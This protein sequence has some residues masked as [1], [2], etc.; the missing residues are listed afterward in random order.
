MNSCRMV[1]DQIS[2]HSFYKITMKYFLSHKQFSIY[3]KNCKLAKIFC[4][5]NVNPKF[6]KAHLSWKRWERKIFILFIHRLKKRSK[7]SNVKNKQ[8]LRTNKTTNWKKKCN[9]YYKKWWRFYKKIFAITAI[10]IYIVVSN[11]KIYH[12]L[13]FFTY[14]NTW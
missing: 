3:I 1:D 4:I 6:L 9:I 2:Y 10:T 5:F 8:T 13:F 14:S 12:I 11:I 7:K